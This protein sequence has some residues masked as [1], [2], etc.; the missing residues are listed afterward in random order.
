MWL[1]CSRF[2]H[3]WKLTSVTDT[4]NIHF[5][6]IIVITPEPLQLCARNLISEGFTSIC[7]FKCYMNSFTCIT[8]LEHKN[9]TNCDVLGRKD[10]SED[11]NYGLLESD[12]MWS[13]ILVP[14]FRKNL[15]R[16]QGSGLHFMLWS[17]DI[18]EEFIWIKMSA[19]FVIGNKWTARKDIKFKLPTV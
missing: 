1:C 18:S 19:C 3:K 8:E 13:G 11:Q 4:R 6:W 12:V 17:L 7:A 5:L 15:L 16:A 9:H 10:R 14:R 2:G